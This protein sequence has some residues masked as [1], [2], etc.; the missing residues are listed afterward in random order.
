L[1][2]L[3]QIVEDA[4]TIID[5]LYFLDRINDEQYDTLIR[6]SNFAKLKLQKAGKDIDADTN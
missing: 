2:S 5:T 1:T 3:Q 6:L 4:D